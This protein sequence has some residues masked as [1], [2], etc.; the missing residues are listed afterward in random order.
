M[1][2]STIFLEHRDRR[3]LVLRCLKTSKEDEA[4]KYRVFVV[5]VVAPLGGST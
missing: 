3:S 1:P 4:I 2:G 5:V